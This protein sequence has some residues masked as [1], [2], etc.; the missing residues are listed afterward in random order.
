MKPRYPS[1]IIMALICMLG[2]W[3]RFDALDWGL[4]FR[5]HPDEWKYVQGAANCHL[6]QWNPRYFRNP[7]GYTY[8]NALWYPVW[9]YISPE[10]SIPDWFLQKQSLPDTN[11]V[12]ETYHSHPYTLVLGARVVSALFGVG[13]ILL[14]FWLALSLKFDERV[15]WISSALAAVSFA[16]VRESHFAV[17]DT[18]MAFWALLSINMGLYSLRAGK[19]RWLY[20]AAALSGIAV[21]MKY[22]AYPAVI[23]L[24]LFRLAPLFKIGSYNASK[25]YLVRDVFL[26][27]CISILSFLLI[28]PFPVLDNPTFMAEMK[29]LSNAA[30]SG[31]Q[32]QDAVWSGFLLMESVWRSEGV[33]SV[34]MA[35]YGSS[36]LFKEKRW[37]FFVFPAIYAIMI[38]SNPLYFTRFCLPLLPWVILAA[39][40]GLKQLYS[41]LPSRFQNSMILAV[42][43]VLLMAQPLI[44]SLRSNFLLHQEDTRIQALRWLLSQDEQSVMAAGQFELPLVYWQTAEPWSTQ[45]S[46]N[47]DALPSGQLNQINQYPVKWIAVSTFAAFPGKIPDNFRDRL[48]AVIQFTQTSQPH[49]AFTVFNRNTQL[50]IVTREDIRSI[51]QADVEDTYSPTTRLWQRER[52]GPE[53]LIFAIRSS[54]QER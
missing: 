52:P 51:K 53:I 23:T 37:D 19:I 50:E 35:V 54:G 27:G 25:I 1:L 13:V 16:G 42:C 46:L 5:L 6:G 21:A 44:S 39:S 11:T 10:T 38:L 30:A 20:M 41:I 15:A 40:I 29:L 2:T 32:G 4:P 26:T 45:Y 48:Q 49:Q 12:A 43:V 31:W 9:I 22:S 17:N 33:L 28:C 7:P 3:L 8:T 14:V 34:I 24:M 47:I 36:I 18:A